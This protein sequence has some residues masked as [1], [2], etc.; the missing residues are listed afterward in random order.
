MKEIDE[1]I[2]QILESYKK[3]NPFK[4][5][6]G[7]FETFNEKLNGR[8]KENEQPAVRRLWLYLKPVA[9]LA[10]AFALVFMLV[11]VPLVKFMPGKDYMANR[12]DS[13]ATQEQAGDSTDKA[14]TVLAYFTE[15]QFL[16]VIDG[17]DEYEKTMVVNS[18][19]VDLLAF[20]CSDWDIV[21]EN[22]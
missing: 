19:V 21:I 6:D 3:P 12:S 22:N 14:G 13:A 18:D 5:P 10:A 20:N 17:A 8:I 9:G 7:Y 2:E 4:V 15:S 16:S 11:Y 1:N